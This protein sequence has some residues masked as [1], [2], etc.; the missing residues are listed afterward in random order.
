MKNSDVKD[1]IECRRK[2]VQYIEYLESE[3]ENIPEPFFKHVMNNILTKASLLALRELLNSTNEKLNSFVETH[4]MSPK[5]S[6]EALIK[7]KD[8]A[9]KHCLILEIKH[10][11]TRKNSKSIEIKKSKIK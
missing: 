7:A 9:L 3:N 1:T 4:K 11:H 10:N 2:I 8:K 5:E 6:F